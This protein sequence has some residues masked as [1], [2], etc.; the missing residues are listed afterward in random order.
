M[1]VKKQK[2]LSNTEK[3][4]IGVGLTAAA[5]AAAGAYFL[6]G[7]KNAAKNRKAVKSWALKAKA[8]VLEGLEKAQQMSQ[9]EYEALI[10]QVGAAYTQVQAASKADISGFKKEMK[11]HWQKIAKSAA[12]K[13]KTVKKAVATK[14]AA[15]ATKVATDAVAKKVAKKAAK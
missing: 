2:G 3:M 10:E 9:A 6:A 15:A 1:A 13:K 11:E 4:S 7:S 5:V 12:P 14:V 8:E